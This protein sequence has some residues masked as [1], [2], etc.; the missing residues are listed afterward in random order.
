[1]GR[2]VRITGAGRIGKQAHLIALERVPICLGRHPHDS[3]AIAIRAPSAVSVLVEADVERAD[4][5]PR[6]AAA[7]EEH[8]RVAAAQHSPS[9]DGAPAA[10]RVVVFVKGEVG[11]PDAELVQHGSVDGRVARVEVASS[12]VR[13][14]LRHGHV[15]HTAP[16]GHDEP[17]LGRSVEHVG[18][19]AG[20]R[21]V[22]ARVIRHA[23]GLLH[24]PLVRSARLL[25]MN[26]VRVAYL[27]A[28]RSGM[29]TPIIRLQV[30]Q[31]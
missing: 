15:D 11:G 24:D 2:G 1:M 30:G 3:V 29:R 6:V 27:F 10:P 28:V 7:C 16:V 22:V 23:E 9:Y 25:C 26:R 21:G 17:T 19:R 13:Q 18:Q 5:V 20:G 31:A 12:L 14:F 8:G 4:L